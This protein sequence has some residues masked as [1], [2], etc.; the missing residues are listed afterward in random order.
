MAAIIVAMAVHFVT[1]AWRRKFLN[2]WRE[3]SK[4]SQHCNI[5]NPTVPQSHSLRIPTHKRG[6]HHN[7]DADPFSALF[8]P[9]QRAVRTRLL[10]QRYRIKIRLVER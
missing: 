10:V 8:T 7:L 3:S 5:T 6:R 1:W 2:S 9:G 4:K